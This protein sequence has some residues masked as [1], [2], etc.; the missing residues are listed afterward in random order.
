MTRSTR[1]WVVAL[2]ACGCIIAAVSFWPDPAITHPPGILVPDEPRQVPVTNMQPW[3]RDEYTITPLAEFSARVRVL[4]VKTY[5][6]GRESDL[7][8]ID[9]ALGWKEMSDQRVLDKIEISQ[10][11]RWYEWHAS[12]LPVPRRVIACSSANMHMIPADQET[13]RAL[14]SLR[15]GDIIA[16]NG[17]LVDVR[18]K[19]GWHWRSSLSRTDEGNGACELVW[20]QHITVE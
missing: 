16:I 3:Q 12:R 20:L 7:S 11:G 1:I 9:L 8:P 4:H 5:H 17:Y 2:L 18:G 13:D 14:S 19:D 10:S 6:H 15:I